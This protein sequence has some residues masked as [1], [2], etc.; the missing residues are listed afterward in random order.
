[1][2][3]FF[4]PISRGKPRDTH[5]S[6]NLG[7]AHLK[8]EKKN[9]HT[10]RYLKLHQLS[11]RSELSQ[12]KQRLKKLYD[13]SLVLQLF[14]LVQPRT[15][16]CPH[17]CICIHLLRHI[18]SQ[19]ICMFL[20]NSKFWRRSPRLFLLCCKHHVA[21]KCRGEEESDGI[22]LLFRFSLTVTVNA[23]ERA[24]VFEKNCKHNRDRKAR[25]S[26]TFPS[27]SAQRWI[28]ELSTEVFL[29]CILKL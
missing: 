20:V 9:Q 4:I 8:K 23:S 21:V 5:R 14:S 6:I 11:L 2:E 7:S 16:D 18:Q 24:F 1:M 25:G 26:L 19:S 27:H 10:M 12:F 15:A 29:Q 3:I 22:S 28:R 17:I 13:K